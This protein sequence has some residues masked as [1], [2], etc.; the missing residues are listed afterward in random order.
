M[1]GELPENSSFRVT[2][3]Q[4]DG[5][6]GH[7]SQFADR[8]AHTIIKERVEQDSIVTTKM[9][10]AYNALNASDFHHHRID[11]SRLF[12][13]QGNHIKGIENFLN[14]TTPH[15]RKFNAISLNTFTGS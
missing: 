15:L 6:Y 8:T 5:L 14:Q 4:R 11:H 10:R 7:N 1:P 2:E 3:A 12:A 9:F 13:K